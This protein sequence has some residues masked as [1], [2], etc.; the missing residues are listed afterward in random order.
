MNISC[1]WYQEN[2]LNRNAQIIKFD[3]LKEANK[4]D[5]CNCLDCQ[6]DRFLDDLLFEVE[7]I[8]QENYLKKE[9]AI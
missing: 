6:N 7:C 1:K 5:D 9:F 2:V 8:E 4:K 3:G